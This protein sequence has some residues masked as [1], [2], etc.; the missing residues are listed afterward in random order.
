M[1]NTK[2]NNLSSIKIPRLLKG[3]FLF[4][5]LLM[6]ETFCYITVWNNYFFFVFKIKTLI[7]HYLFT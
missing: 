5:N 6:T 3:D 1:L 7:L 2:N 4:N